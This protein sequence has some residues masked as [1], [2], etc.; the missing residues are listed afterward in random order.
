LQHSGILLVLLAVEGR[1]FF[2]FSFMLH[3]TV[4]LVSCTHNT[5][6]STPPVKS[7]RHLYCTLLSS[8]MPYSS[9]MKMNNEVISHI[10]TVMR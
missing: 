7:N 2:F 10:I 5:L 6:Q 4:F 8:P 1:Q 3:I 9:F